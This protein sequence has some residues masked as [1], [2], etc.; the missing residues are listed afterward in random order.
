MRNVVLALAIV[1]ALPGC[2]TEPS[3]TTNVVPPYQPEAIEPD[4]PGPEPTAE[5]TASVEMC[6]LRLVLHCKSPN[7][8]GEVT[9]RYDNCGE[10]DLAREELLALGWFF[11]DGRKCKWQEHDDQPQTD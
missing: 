3:V 7:T 6:E 4:A 5:P 2:G 10:A 11:M 1:A 8:K 9:L